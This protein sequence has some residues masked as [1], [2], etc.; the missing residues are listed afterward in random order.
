MSEKNKI[1]MKQLKKCFEEAGFFEVSTYLNSGNVIFSAKEDN[2]SCIIEELIK[3]EFGL[4]IPVYII[5]KDELDN[6]LEKA[7]S[8]WGTDDKNLYDNL[9]FVLS[10]DTVENLCKQIGEPSEELE[11]VQVYQNVIFWTFD[12]ARYQKCN[13]WK[14][15]ATDG[16]AERLTIRTANTVRKVCK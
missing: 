2:L 12:R 1:D 8:W 10:D 15:T 14:R 7:P 5:K 11:K 16:I 6:I 9:I 3:A 13:W 4:D